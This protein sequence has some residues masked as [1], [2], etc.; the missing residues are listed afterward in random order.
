MMGQLVGPRVQLAVGHAP[1]AVEQGDGFRRARRLCFKKLVDALIVWIDSGG[2]VPLHQELMALGHA[3]KGQGGQALP[4]ISNDAFEQ[5]LKMPEH[6]RHGRRLEQVGAVLEYAGQA[7]VDLRHLD[8]QV[9]LRGAAVE[10]QFIQGQ[11][12]QV[13]PLLWERSG[14]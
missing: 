5:R 6:A 12:R 2:I 14:G 8:G 10:L 13:K 3:H 4:G 11:T 7:V 1:V 9:K